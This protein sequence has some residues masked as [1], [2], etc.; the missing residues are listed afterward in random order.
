M[1]S[2]SKWEAIPAAP[3]KPQK[4]H[5][6]TKGE[7]RLSLCNEVGFSLRVQYVFGGPKYS[8]CNGDMVWGHHILTPDDSSCWLMRLHWLHHFHPTPF[9]VPF[10]ST[11]C[12]QRKQEPNWI[13][14][15]L[16]SFFLPK[17]RKP[18]QSFIY[19]SSTSIQ[20]NMGNG[21]ACSLATLSRNGALARHHTQ[22]I[23]KSGGA[24][25]RPCRLLFYSHTGYSKRNACLNLDVVLLRE[26]SSGRS[27][28]V[29]V[30]SIRLL[31]TLTPHTYIFFNS[32]TMKSETK[33][34]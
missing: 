21:V 4:H 3:P 1:I 7:Q 22:L 24:R 2:L 25:A 29:S 23:S 30:K 19:I 8:C 33:H 15:L 18:W 32:R 12:W 28:W 17:P 5:L 10:S 6:R 26:R 27:Y 14:L 16:K 20:S 31:N 9:Q 13:T 34:K 11:S